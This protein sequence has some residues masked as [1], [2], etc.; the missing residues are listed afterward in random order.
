MLSKVCLLIFFILISEYSDFFILSIIKNY[1]FS[2][3]NFLKH[4]I[5]GDF[6]K[7]SKCNANIPP[8]VKGEDGAPLKLSNNHLN[9]AKVNTLSCKCFGKIYFRHNRHQVCIFFKRRIS[10]FYSKIHIILSF[11]ISLILYVFHSNA[12]I[13]VQHR[14]RN[15][16]CCRQASAGLSAFRRV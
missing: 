6:W 2:I 14:I 9:Q 3:T 5:S 13:P 8:T 16:I 7:K 12:A 1:K 11:H 10:A 4:H 15:T